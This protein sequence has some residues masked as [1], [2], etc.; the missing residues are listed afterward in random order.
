[1]HK[2]QVLSLVLS[3]IIIGIGSILFSMHLPYLEQVFRSDGGSLWLSYTLLQIFLGG[4]GVLIGSVKIHCIQKIL[5]ICLFVYIGVAVIWWIS[6]NLYYGLY[7]PGLFHATNLTTRLAFIAMG[8]C[9]IQKHYHRG[10]ERLN[11]LG[12]N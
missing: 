2:A 5:K 7:W 6:A 10:V 8:I 4:I 11:S 12:Y 1:M 3:A 9:F